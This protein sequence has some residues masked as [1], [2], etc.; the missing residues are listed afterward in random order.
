MVEFGTED[1]I[2]EANLTQL[3]QVITNLAVNARDAM[4]EGGELRV[5]L[6]RLLLRP[7]EHLPRAAA[8]GAYRLPELEPG[9]WVVW[10]VSDTGTGMP[11]EVIKHI[12]EPFFT[13]KRP[14]EGTGL[15]LAQVYGIVQ[16]HGG[17]IDVKSEVEKGTTF[18]ICLPQIAKAEVSAQQL[19]T[20]IQSG[21]G[22]TILVVEDEPE[23][24]QVVKVMLE[25]LNYR[26]HTAANGREAQAVY[27]SHRDEIAL[28]L[29]D[30]M[31]PEMG[32]MELFKVLKEKY[33]GVRVVVMTGYPLKESRESQLLPQGVA[34]F[35][36]KPLLLEQVAAVISEMLKCERPHDV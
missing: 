12:W 28:V 20:D 17:Y 32:G 16:H 9:E 13:T 29:T 23:M 21:R 6:S 10:T 35:L 19:G 27:D 3:Q 8:Q 33:P 11:P 36:E 25:S 14:G 26:V 4:P 24:L 34:G 31:M 15:G 22:E 1:Y 18:M 2:V 5:G 30:M 7:D